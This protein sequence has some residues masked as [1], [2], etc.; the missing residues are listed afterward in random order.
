MDNQYILVNCEEG[1]SQ[2][3]GGRFWRLT[4]QSLDDGTTH[5]MTVD[6]AYKNFKRSGWNHV[7]TDPYPYGVY[8]GL[9]RTNK[10]TAKGVP[11]VSADGRARI[12][13]RCV[14][15]AELARLVQANTDSFRKP[16]TTFGQLF[17]AG[18]GYDA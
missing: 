17:D 5:E 6:P 1:H 13:Y 9:R 2:L 10:T 4:F 3:N 11:V 8:E 12:V 7:V 16:S 14:D 18:N 15:D